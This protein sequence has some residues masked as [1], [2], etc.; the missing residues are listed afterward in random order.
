SPLGGVV[1]VG[2]QAPHLSPATRPVLQH[3]TCPVV[4]VPDAG[5]PPAGTVVVGVTPHEHSRRP[6]QW[7]AEAASLRHAALVVV[8]AWQVHPHSAWDIFH[9]AVSAGKQQVELQS[10]LESWVQSEIGGAAN[11]VVRTIH[12]AP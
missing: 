9:P 8:Q 2:C 3:A 12:A 11:T 6:L 10:A 1:A 5:E 7:A 4:V